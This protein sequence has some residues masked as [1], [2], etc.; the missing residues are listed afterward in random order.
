MT[1]VTFDPTTLPDRDY[2]LRMGWASVRPPEPAPH[3][4]TQDGLIRK[5]RVGTLPLTEYVQA[6][7]LRYLAAGLT[8]SGQVRKY[9]IRKNIQRRLTAAAT[10]K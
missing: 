1:N 7:R 4:Y 6:L 8:T 5:K 3:G 2:Y 9:K 10:Q